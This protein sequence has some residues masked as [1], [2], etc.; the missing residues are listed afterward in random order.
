VTMPPGNSALTVHSF[1]PKGNA[2]ADLL[3]SGNWLLPLLYLALLVDYGATFFLRT[4]TDARSPYLAVVV[5]AHL[6]FLV[7]RGVHIGYPPVTNA[8]EIASVLALATAGVYA[9]VELASRDRRTGVFVLL[10]AFLFQYT[11]SMLLAGRVAEPS[12]VSL[13]AVGM[14][15]RLHVVPA[16]VAYTALAFAGVYGLLYLL[17][18]RGLRRHRFGVLFDRLPPLDVLG[19]MAWHALLTGFVAM[20]VAIAVAPL[21]FGKGGGEMT[22]K[23]ISKIIT[24]SVAWVVYAVA[25]LGRWLGKWPASRIST[26]A[27]VGFLVV[28]A[29]LTVSGLL[30]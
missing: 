28:M 3:A 25:I 18:H 2:M 21:L 4:R 7:L 20:T 6:A 27:V 13:G 15:A 9:W 11:S 26:I 24:G 17:E 10:L 8:Q 23:V 29:L 19:P 30:S 1:L 5:A 14:W 12:E 16:L 22:A